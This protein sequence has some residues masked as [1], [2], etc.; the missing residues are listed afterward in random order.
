MLYIS[1]YE[2]LIVVV[3]FVVIT[4]GPPIAAWALAIVRRWKERKRQA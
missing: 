2:I 4:F 3:V 1:P